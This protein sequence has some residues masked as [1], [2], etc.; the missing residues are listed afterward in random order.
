ME[1]PT[2]ILTALLRVPPRGRVTFLS[3]QESNQRSGPD[4]HPCAGQTFVRPCTS[5]V[6]PVAAPALRLSRV[7][8]AVQGRTNAARAHGCAKRPTRPNQKTIRAQT[9]LAHCSG[10]SGGARRAPTGKRQ[11]QRQHPA[12]FTSFIA[13]Y[14]SCGD[15][16]CFIAA[17]APRAGY[18]SLLV[19]RK[20]TKRKHTPI[21]RRL[22]EPASAL[23]NP[24]PLEARVRHPWRTRSAAGQST[25]L[26]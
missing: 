1:S 15:A 18:F 6:H 9:V 22:F 25:G 20:V 14:A 2:A 11:Q 7:S 17:P 12:Q 16:D 5:N 13:P 21:A 26:S 23:R 4:A 8:R 3:R 19:Q 10:L 24:A